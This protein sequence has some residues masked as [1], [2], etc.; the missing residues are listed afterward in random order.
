MIAAAHPT[1][2]ER[3]RGA[4]PSL[5]VHILLAFLLLR[6]LAV[7]ASTASEEEARLTVV[8]LVPPPPALEIPPPPPAPDPGETVAPPGGL[9]IEAERRF[10]KATILL[11]RSAAG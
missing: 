8:G 11:L 6:G 10:G 3:L 2:F 1:P 9:N 5:A 7:G 4:L